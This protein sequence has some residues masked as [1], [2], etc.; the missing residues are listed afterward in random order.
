MTTNIRICGAAGQGVQSFGD[1]LARTFASMG[2][3]V[4]ATQSYLSRI[5]GGINSYDVRIGSEELFSSARKT[6]LLVALN[7]ESMEQ[8]KA[9]LALNGV[10]ILN[11]A[12]SGGN[13]L[14]LQMDKLAQAAGGTA[15]MANSAGA[16]AVVS[17]LGYDLD[18]LHKCLTEE[19]SKKGRDIVEQNLDAA[20][21]GYR[22]VAGHEGLVR[23]PKPAGAPS[24][25][26]DGSTAIAI[27]AATAGVKIVFSYPMTPS[28]GVLTALAGLSH[29]YGMVVEQ[30][31]DEIAAP[32]LLCGAAFAGVPAMTTTSGGG[33]ALM[34]EGLSLAGMLELPIVIFLSMRPGPATGMPTRTAQ[35]DLAFAAHAGHGEF[36]KIILAPGDLRQAF[37]LT[38]HAFELAH[39]FQTPVILVADQ[40]LTDL[41][42]NIPALP[43]APDYINLHLAKKSAPGKA[44]ERYLV[45]DNGVSPRAVPGGD[46]YVVSAS[47]MHAEGGH[48]SE[49][50]NVQIALQDKR[51]RKITGILNEFIK[52]EIYPEPAGEILLCW[53]STYGPCRAAVNLLR[54]RGRD[55]CMVHF[56][57]VW[58]LD[59]A[60]LA[61]LFEG[62]R[63]IAV[64][65][66]G[67]GQF[68]LLLR[69]AG[70]LRE[71]SLLPRYDGLPFTAEFIETEVLS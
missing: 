31:E 28:S 69:Q 37:D 70:A 11:T 20:S 50:F 46:S 40:F 14:A 45:T 27:G 12:E 33:F 39:K 62:R 64:E 54:A 53:G 1:L 30:A 6:D 43:D 55:V 58:P 60:A 8:E 71:F 2:L 35:G 13:Y 49:D 65:G 67:T 10:M 18:A 42:K 48:L 57:M 52:P 36:P 7:R 59:G 5:R 44:Y 68:A 41:Q 32:N 25:L 22:A 63:V 66:N 24:T 19:F 34:A 15:R 26:Y 3:H 61:P 23:A 51:M 4:F 47:D 17:V 38:R 29:K 56:P 16:G 21:R 9:N